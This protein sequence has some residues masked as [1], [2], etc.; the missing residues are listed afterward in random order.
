M[1]LTVR[2]ALAA[3]ATDATDLLNAIIRAGGTTAMQ[4][5]LSAAQTQDW[6]LHGP[7]VQCAHVAFDGAQM[8][9]WQSVG[10]NATLPD[11]W[12]DMATFARIGSTARGIGTALFAATLARAATLGL[13]HLNATIRADNAG[14]LA[15]YARMGFAEYD[16]TCAVPLSD[17]TPVDRIHKRR[18]V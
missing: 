18:A 17:G 12:G 8:V 9:G 1:V 2:A 11:G 3:D 7:N 5:G 6:F 14:G 13:H 4:T 15:Y 10:R 16:R